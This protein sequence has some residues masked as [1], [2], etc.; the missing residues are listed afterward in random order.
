MLCWVKTK[1]ELKIL[2]FY[3]FLHN[4]INQQKNDSRLSHEAR[5]LLYP[6]H[7]FNNADIY[8]VVK[9]ERDQNYPHFLEAAIIRIIAA[10]GSDSE[11]VN[12]IPK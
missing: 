11:F 1:R 4:L 10:S 7:K 9:S 5:D 8:L 2:R 12:A 6:I 3:I